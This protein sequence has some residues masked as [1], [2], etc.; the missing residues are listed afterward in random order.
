MAA[1]IN[2]HRYGTKLRHC[3][4]TV[5]IERTF[6]KNKIS[7][8]ACYSKNLVDDSSLVAEKKNGKLQY[9]TVDL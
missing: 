7:L 5:R 1:K 6:A 8:F 2:W 3:H 4:R 9:T